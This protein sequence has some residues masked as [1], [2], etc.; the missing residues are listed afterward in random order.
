MKEETFYSLISVRFKPN[1]DERINIG[2]L[3]N[4]GHS[5]L[6]D[7]SETKF[8]LTVKFLNQDLSRQLKQT[9]EAL[10]K[11]FS[12]TGNDIDFA[13]KASKWDTG[14]LQYLSKYS[15][16]FL[17]FSR[18]EP[19]K[20]ELNKSNFDS[21]FKKYVW[22]EDSKEIKSKSSPFIQRVNHFYVKELD[23]RTDINVELTSVDLK[24]LL[25]PVKIDSL[26]FNENPFSCEAIDFTA[27]VNA[28]KPKMT[29]IL[30]LHEAFRTNKHSEAKMFCI[31]K[32]N[33]SKD[34]HGKS[35]L[36]NLKES[37]L[38]ELVS[39]DETGIISEYVEDHNVKP[40]FSQTM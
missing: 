16:N 5:L 25:F 12:N 35:L 3:M 36:S 2:L 27:H 23:K 31:F 15:Q 14:T 38:C 20:L 28:I 39:E 13:F 11:S 9:L 17:V 29:S 21:L 10:R 22:L 30:H 24:G 1:T 6:F 37:G 18:P 4:N 26:G 8:E 19:I 7:Y 32:E 34:S 40:W 33:Q